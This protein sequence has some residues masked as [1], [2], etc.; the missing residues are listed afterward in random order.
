MPLAALIRARP[1]GHLRAEAIDHVSLRAMMT[2]YP[3]GARNPPLPAMFASALRAIRSYAA[4][5]AERVRDHAT[6]AG[7]PA[8]EVHVI[9]HELLP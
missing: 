5:T 6:A 4:P 1:R 3:L 8:D 2:R 9:A 7:L